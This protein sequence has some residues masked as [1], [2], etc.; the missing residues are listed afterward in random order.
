MRDGF[1]MIEW[2]RAGKGGVWVG[3]ITIRYLSYEVSSI[4]DHVE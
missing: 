4:L 3:Y 2:D 1:S